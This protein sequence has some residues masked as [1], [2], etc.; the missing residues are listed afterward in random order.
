MANTNGNGEVQV[1]KYT[2]KDF[3]SD[4]DVRWCPGCGDYSILAQVQ[5]ILPDLYVPKEKHVFVSGIGCSSK[6]PAYFLQYSHGFNALHGR[7]PSAAT[8]AAI[9]TTKALPE[10]QGRFDGVAVRG[11]VAV[12]S[13]SDL[14]FVLGRDATAEEV[15]A[16]LRE[17][18][19][20]A[21]YR[22]GLGVTE[23]PPVSR[24]IITRGSWVPARSS[25]VGIVYCRSCCGAFTCV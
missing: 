20:T 2:A 12:G 4:Q 6:T 19:A 22:E 16:A 7:M 17:E 3:A 9:A 11:P 25:A 23:D 21:R 5:R 14:V 13:I 1:K 8:G 18:A 24:A 15:N 10:V